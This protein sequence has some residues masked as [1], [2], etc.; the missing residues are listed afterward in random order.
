MM[1][2]GV[3][4]FTAMENVVFGKPAAETVA[5]RAQSKDARRVFLIVSGTLNRE[6]DEIDKVIKALGD[7]SL[8]T[9]PRKV[10]GPED[11]IEILKSAA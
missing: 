11:V 8:H 9:N 10:G 2:S 6:T 5:S 7:R 1:Q 4:S 3:F